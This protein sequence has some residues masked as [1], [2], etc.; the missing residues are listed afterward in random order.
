MP[1]KTRAKKTLK[2]Y[3]KTATTSKNYPNR[4]NRSIGFPS[5]M[6]CRLRYCE[7]VS[8]SGVPPLTQQFRLNSLHDPDFTGGGH[9]PM[10]YNQ[11]K[12]IYGS[13]LVKNCR[14]TVSVNQ[15]NANDYP[16]AFLLDVRNDSTTRTGTGISQRLEDG[17]SSVIY[18]G[19]AGG[20][21][22]AKSMSRNVNIGRQYGLRRP[23]TTLDSDWTA[24]VGSNPVNTVFATIQGCAVSSSTTSISA[25]LQITLDFDCCFFNKL[26]TAQST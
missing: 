13:W 10:Y 2:P 22:S 14:I 3:R 21:N 15:T 8:F 12:L 20:G 23:L 1:R 4:I 9:F 6:N 25:F 17:G 11:L 19:Y 5:C 26:E 16:A 24:P 7:T 18:V